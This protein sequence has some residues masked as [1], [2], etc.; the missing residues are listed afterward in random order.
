MEAALNL[1]EISYESGAIK[2]RYTRYLA[3]DGTRWVRH[4]LFVAYHEDGVVSSEGNYAHGAEDGV[5]RDFH[6]NG[7]LAAEGNY[8][9]GQETGLWRFWSEDGL[10]Q[11]QSF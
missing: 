11:P 4:G 5:W 7:Q 6:P 2:F 3:S 1:A 9:D 10:E 8:V